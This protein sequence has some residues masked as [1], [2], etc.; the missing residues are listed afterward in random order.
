M[1]TGGV[2]DTTALMLPAVAVAPV[3]APGT[4]EGVTPADAVLATD[5]RLA[6]LVAV[7][8]NVYEVPFVSPV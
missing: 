8:V 1:L 5:V 7:T 6:L 2:H 3:G 4:V